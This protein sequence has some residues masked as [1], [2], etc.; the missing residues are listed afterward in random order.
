VQDLRDGAD[1]GEVQDA[2]DAGALGD[3]QAQALL[4]V[5]EPAGEAEQQSQTGAVEERDTRQVD[6]Q[7]RVVVG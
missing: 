2:R 6:D 5:A 4:A 3:D 7:A 1:A